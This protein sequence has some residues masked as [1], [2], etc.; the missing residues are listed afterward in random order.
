MTDKALTSE[1]VIACNPNAVP[2]DRREQWIENG[3]QVYAAVLEV[4]EISDGYG[5]RVPTDSAMLLKVAEYIPNERLCCLFLHF[6]VEIE[7]NGGSIWLRLAGGEGVK[8]YMRSVFETTMLLSEG[9]SKTAGFNVST[10]AAWVHP[11]APN[12]SIG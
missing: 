6:T 3:K 8:T 5:F 10:S 9:V 1:V 2:I 4:Q 12:L 7:S 11:S